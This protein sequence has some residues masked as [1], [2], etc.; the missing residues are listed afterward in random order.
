[1]RTSAFRTLT[2]LPILYS[3]QALANSGMEDKIADVVVWI[4][5]I[6]VP[7]V[8]VVAFWIVHIWPERVAEKK[9]HSQAAA[10]QALCLLSS[11]SAACSGRS[12]C[13]GPT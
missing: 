2:A 8:L 4:V 9:H 10:I 6:V 11:C 12:R 3:G 7:I 5:V 1:M 13:S